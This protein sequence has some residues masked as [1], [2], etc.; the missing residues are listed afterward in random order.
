V[1]F[2]QF[3]V[4]QMNIY[5]DDL[6]KQFEKQQTF[7]LNQI[8]IGFYLTYGPLIKVDNNSTKKTDRHD[9]AESVN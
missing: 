4:R 8:Q 7:F 9:I 5:R 3:K 6:R 2:S 1:I